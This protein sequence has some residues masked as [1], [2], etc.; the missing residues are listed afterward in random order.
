MKTVLAT[1][2]LVGLAGPGWAEVEKYPCVRDKKTGEFICQAE[3][4]TKPAPNELV[5][6]L[7]NIPPTPQMDAEG[8]VK[9]APG[10]DAKMEAAM[11][12]VNDF[13]LDAGEP[14]HVL[15][16]GQ[17]LYLIMPQEFII[18]WNAVARDCWRN[19]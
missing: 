18:E 10:C 6:Q 15:P 4:C 11:R 17:T 16:N 7:P 19:P 8:R 13:V 5:C 2:L 12:H 1:I 14:L 9:Y 3:S